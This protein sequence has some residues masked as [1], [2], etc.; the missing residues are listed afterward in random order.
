MRC[1]WFSSA[2]IG[3]STVFL[4]LPCSIASG[5]SQYS[6]LSLTPILMGNWFPL[7]ALIFTLL[8]LIF[9]LTK[10]DYGQMSPVCL[11]LS[12]ASQGL[13]WYFFSSFCLVSGAAALLQVTVLFQKYLPGHA[14]CSDA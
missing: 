7:M 12:L 14:K 5:G 11:I 13:S 2:G 6:H 4:C 10:R 1:K 3:L 9:L 8:A